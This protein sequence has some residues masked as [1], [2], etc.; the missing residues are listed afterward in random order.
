MIAN[1]HR[2]DKYQ[3]F[4]HGLMCGENKCTCVGEQAGGW[5]EREYST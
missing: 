3:E 5:K 2:F 4:N 1:L